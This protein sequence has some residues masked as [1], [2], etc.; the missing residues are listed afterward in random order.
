MDNTDYRDAWAWVH[1][2]LHR[3]Q[4]SRTLLNGYLAKAKQYDEG[5]HFHSQIPKVLPDLRNEFVA[6]FR[7]YPVILDR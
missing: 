6:H 1:F 4:E 3:S 7:S 5:F 2:M